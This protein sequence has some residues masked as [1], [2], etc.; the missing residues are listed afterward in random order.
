MASISD[1][2]QE[3]IGFELQADVHDLFMRMREATEDHGWR[4]TAGAEAAKHAHERYTWKRV[5]ESMVLDG[6]F[7]PVH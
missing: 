7:T 4:E 5:V 6:R 3:I 2:G 1:L